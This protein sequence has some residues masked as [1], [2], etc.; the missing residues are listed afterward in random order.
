MYSLLKAIRTVKHV[1]TSKNRLK[2]FEDIASK[3]TLIRMA[4]LAFQNTAHT[5]IGTLLLLVY[6]LK[7]FMTI[8][9]PVKKST[10]LLCFASYPNEHIAI[11]RIKTEFSGVDINDLLISKKYIFSITNWIA[12]LSYI[13]LIPHLYSFA[14]NCSNN[15]HFMPACRVFSTV[16]FYFRFKNILGQLN[17]KGILVANHYSPECTAL[18]AAAKNMSIKVIF[19]NHAHTPEQVTFPS[20]PPVDLALLTSG[21]VYHK[22]ISKSKQHIRYKLIGYEQNKKPLQLDFSS[23]SKLTVG[24]FFTALTNMDRV[25]ILIDRFLNAFHPKKILLRPHPVTLLK[26]NFSGIQ[27][28]YS[29]VKISKNTSLNYDINQCDLIVCGNTG[30]VIEILKGGCPVLYDAELDQITYDYNGFIEGGLIPSAD[31]INNQLLTKLSKFYKREGWEKIM[32]LYDASYLNDK[33]V[34][35]KEAE[36]DLK[37][38]LTQ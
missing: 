14:R 1:D 13:L 17:I 4:Y 2:V 15:L 11:N 6:G 24:I 38:V 22:L 18:M 34:L 19:T 35:L 5:P 16:A 37:R 30:A 8:K 29:V 28:D 23:N 10:E 3:H 12:A 27:Q 25:R 9:L 21:A 33:N 26:E 32:Q 31:K 7:C 20:S 36:I